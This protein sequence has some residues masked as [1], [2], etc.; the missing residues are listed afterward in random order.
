MGDGAVGILQAGL[1]L[2][3]G[4]GI[5]QNIGTSLNGQMPAPPANVLL[6]H[7]PSLTLPALIGPSFS[8]PPY[9]HGP[10]PPCP[11]WP[12][13]PYPSPSFAAPSLPFLAIPGP[14]CL[15]ST[16]LTRPL[17]MPASA[18]AFTFRSSLFARTL[19][20]PSCV[21]PTQPFLHLILPSL[22]F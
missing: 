8:T 7:P 19:S 5:K 20:R 4:I 12:L 13:F 1:M 11:D 18:P 9:P 10:L 21:L 6:D 14:Y 16:T 17:P 22:S 15:P 3:H 2:F